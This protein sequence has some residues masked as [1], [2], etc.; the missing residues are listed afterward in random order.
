MVFETLGTIGLLAI[1]DLYTRHALT[2]VLGFSRPPALRDCMFLPNV[3]TAIVM[4]LSGVCFVM[5]D[6]TRLE[7]V[8][9]WRSWL[10]QFGAPVWTGWSIGVVATCLIARREIRRRNRNHAATPTR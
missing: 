9:A 6:A 2:Q 4:V 10:F 7:H 1:V 8:P 5:G 3:P